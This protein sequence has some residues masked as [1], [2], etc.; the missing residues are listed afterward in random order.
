MKEIK[1]ENFNSSLNHEI[2]LK[3][4]I[5]LWLELLKLLKTD[6]NNKLT[7]LDDLI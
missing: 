1:I 6:I 7:N 5:N 2:F 3:I 4:D